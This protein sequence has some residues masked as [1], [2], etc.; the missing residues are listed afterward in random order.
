MLGKLPR[1]FFRPLKLFLSKDSYLKIK[2][3]YNK[4]AIQPYEIVSLGTSC[5]PKTI[6]TRHKLKKTKADGE[7]SLP[8]DL[9]WFHEAVFVTEFIKNNFDGFF[10]DMRYIENI[11]CWDN[12]TKIN[13]SHETGFGPEDKD[14]L[15][16]KYTKRIENF[17]KIMDSDRPVLF[18]QF[19]KTPS[20][21]EDSTNLYNVLKEK[22]NGKPF[23]LLIIDCADIIKDFAPEINVLKL[24]LP[25]EDVNLYDASFYKSKAG[26]KFEKNIIN[27][28]KSLIKKKFN[29]NLTI[30]L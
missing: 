16:E 15:I 1:M 17:S 22:R 26:K 27:K 12:Y 25:S 8:F 13:F 18:I 19:L 28:C 10:S 30:Y 9:A 23:E 21:G 11:N 7:L 3:H 5:Y 4:S 14:L 6:L 29:F 2:D 24:T 20:V